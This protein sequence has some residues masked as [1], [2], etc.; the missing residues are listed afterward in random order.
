MTSVNKVDR[1]I[2]FSQ[3]QFFIDYRSSQNGCDRSLRLGNE[4]EKKY[5]ANIVEQPQVSSTTHI[6]FKNGNLETKLFAKKYNIPLVDPMWLEHSI[7]K[8][9]LIKIDKYQVQ[10]DENQQPAGYFFLE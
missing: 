7:K 8:R 1:A 2:L 5:G 10:N 3:C 9:R 4:L 6:I